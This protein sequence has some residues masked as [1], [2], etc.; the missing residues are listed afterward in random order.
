VPQAEVRP[1][2]TVLLGVGASFGAGERRYLERF[3]R[4]APFEWE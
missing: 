3:R 2:F 1:D 4:R